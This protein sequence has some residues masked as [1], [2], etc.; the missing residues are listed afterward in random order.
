MSLKFL[1]L[2]FCIASPFVKAQQFSFLQDGVIEDIVE[3]ADDE[4]KTL[5]DAAEVESDDLP[6]PMDSAL[7]DDKEE[8]EKTGNK[9]EIAFEN[10]DLD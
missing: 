1:I 5:D 3:A 7:D 9:I 6:E 4:S 8:S 2:L 10:I